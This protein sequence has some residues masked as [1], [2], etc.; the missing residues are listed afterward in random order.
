MSLLTLPIFLI[1][2]QPALAGQAESPATQ[3]IR[4]DRGL[5]VVVFPD[6]VRL[7]YDLGLS[8]SAAN[9][10]LK[11]SA[12]DHADI[13]DRRALMEA[14]RDLALPEIQRRCRITVNAS[15][16]ALRAVE[17]RIFPKHYVQLTFIFEAPLADAGD[18]VR[19]QLVDGSFRGCDGNHLIA[20]KTDDGAMLRSSTV[21]L[22]SPRA[23]RAATGSV[24]CSLTR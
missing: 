20:L 21:P 11:K 1:L 2:A 22:R 12:P 13:E 4:V 9:A 17:T 16:L 15:P 8:S 18:V 10:L 7:Q 6:R 19:L 23:W 5:Q 14:F 24:P 3:L